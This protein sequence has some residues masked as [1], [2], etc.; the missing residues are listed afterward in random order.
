ME[1]WKRL[2]S[3]PTCRQS[4][5]KHGF[6]FPDLQNCDAAAKAAVLK[7]HPVQGHRVEVKKAV[8]KEDVHSGGDGGGSRSFQGGRGR[9]RG[10][11]QTV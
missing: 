3:L 7:F 10:P 1:P 8:P 9:G 4:G 11:D 6:C 2:R 5:K